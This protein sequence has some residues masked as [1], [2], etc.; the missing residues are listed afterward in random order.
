M[1]CAGGR[2]MG[3]SAKRGPTNVFKAITAAGRANPARIPWI[4]GAVAAGLSLVIAAGCGSVASR[5]INA[6]GVRLF[7]QSR[8]DEA[9]QQFLQAVYEDPNDPDGYYNLAAT[10]HRMGTLNQRPSDLKQAEHYYRMCLDRAP[11]HRECYRGLAVLLA[12]QG[13]AEE[14][15]A[16]IRSWADRN[17]SSP[18]PKIEL[19][20]LYEEFGDKQT[21]KDYLVSA[22]S[23][24]PENSRALAALG[25]LREETGEH[26]Q[27]LADYERSLGGD[28][29]QEGVRQRVAALRSRLNSGF[30]TNPSTPTPPGGTRVVTGTPNPIR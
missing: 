14:A 25:R 28:R 18:E 12:E 24:E 21:A 30:S 20:R 11:E 13:Q 2:S 29:F 9:V 23:T 26:A 4:G 27:A 5:G 7:E 15:F 22:L 8:Y 10:Y 3:D 17:P 16:L 1:S 19:A 6:E